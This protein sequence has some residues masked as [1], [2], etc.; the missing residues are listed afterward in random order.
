[1]GRARGQMPRPGP[2]PRSRPVR[3]A[4]AWVRVDEVGQCMQAQSTAKTRIQKRTVPSMHK[5][6][7]CLRAR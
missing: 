2:R 1:M 5:P 4:E 6:V 7:D 3:R